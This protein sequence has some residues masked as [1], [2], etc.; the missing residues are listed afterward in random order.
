MEAVLTARVL[1]TA[2]AK[3]NVKTKVVPIDF[4]GDKV[5]YEDLARAIEGEW[6]LHGTWPIYTYNQRKS[7][8]S[9]SLLFLRGLV[10]HLGAAVH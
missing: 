9:L 8:L 6:F 2:E 7:N 4:T 1:F 3:H 5:I 10:R